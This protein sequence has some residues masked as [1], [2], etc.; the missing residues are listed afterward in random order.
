MCCRRWIW[1]RSAEKERHDEQKAPCEH[2]TC[3]QLATVEVRT[4][5]EVYS[6]CDD[7]WEEAWRAATY[8][9]SIGPRVAV[10]VTPIE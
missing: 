6:A 9:Y 1:P 2:P 5:N 8:H 4:I 7:H 10:T 3:D